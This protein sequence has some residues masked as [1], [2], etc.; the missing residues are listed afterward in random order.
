MLI[1]QND[2]V[3]IDIG[4][5]NVAIY[6]CTGKVH[7][8]FDFAK[9]NND[10]LN[11]NESSFIKQNLAFLQKTH[12]IPDYLNKCLSRTDDLR[13]NNNT[14]EIKRSGARSAYWVKQGIKFKGCR[15]I[16]KEP[17]NFPMEKLAFDSNSIEYGIIPFGVLTKEAVIREILAYCF[18]KENKL[19]VAHSPVCVYEYLQENKSIG[20][21]L[22]L[23]SIGETR[24]EQFINYPE[25]SL[26]EL[27]H[28]KSQNLKTKFFIGSELNLHGINVNWYS[29]VKAKLLAEMHFL[30]GFRGILNS[31]IGNDIISNSKNNMLMICDFDTFKVIDVPYNPDFQFLKG[32]VLHCVIEVLKGS[33]S[34]LDY[35]QLQENLS[36]KE[37]NSILFEKYTKT[38]SLWKSYERHFWNKV[39]E[40]DWDEKLVQAAF[41]YILE[42]KPIFKILSLVIPNN[43]AI[44]DI[45]NNRNIFYSHN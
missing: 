11:K 1:K 21:C 26:N 28:I 27:M 20:Y 9:N 24:I 33:I 30:G 31:N 13:I 14:F 32:F 39:I 42:T 10:I 36:V 37:C 41:E 23:D 19:A 17:A 38:S 18:F 7:S 6:E 35:V 40:N 22:V 16:L 4:P 45:T 29:E 12:T 34:I 43:K 15:P 25:L 8:V 5:E 2:K 44:E 3:Q